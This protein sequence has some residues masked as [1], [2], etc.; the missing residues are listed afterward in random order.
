MSGAAG[1]RALRKRATWAE[2]RLWRLLRSRRLA[3][4]KFRRQHPDSRHILD[5]YCI[6]A[7]LVVEL[8]GIGHGLPSRMEM[9]K[10]RDAA[11][12]S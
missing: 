3:G 8:D 1:A 7:K 10:K 11:L 12:A 9:D 4:Y 5:F 6:E 2:K